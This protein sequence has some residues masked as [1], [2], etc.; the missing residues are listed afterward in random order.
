LILDVVWLT[1]LEELGRAT[2][3]ISQAVNEYMAIQTA[4]RGADAVG[5]LKGHLNILTMFVRLVGDREIRN[6]T[7]EHVE[8]FFYGPGG[9][10]DSHPVLASGK[11]SMYP[12]VCNR[13]HN[14]YRSRLTTFFV[15]CER[16]GYIKRGSDL[17]ALTSPLKVQKEVRERPAPVV[18]LRLLEQARNPR[19]RALM[20]TAVNTALRASEITAIRF[21]D[22][23]LESGVI[24]VTVRKTKDADYQPISMDLDR[25]LRKWLMVYASTLG[26]PLA[27]DDVLFP[28]RRGGLISH[29][30]NGVCIRHPY[31]W[32]TQSTIEKPYKIVQ[33]A[34]KSLGLPTKKEGIHT[35]RRAVALA[36]FQQVSKDQGDVAALRETAALLHHSSVATTEIYLGMTPEKNRRDRRIKGQ[37]FLSAMVHQENVIQLAERSGS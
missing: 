9:I 8:K 35:I 32:D 29:Y 5:T 20:A 33:D 2:V 31:T 6:L 17:M 7:D 18:L 3:K 25:E 4:R 11:V 16:K 24:K 19:D 1:L 12:P 13:T 36:Y 22:V 15:W 27:E 37:P 10:R 34:L 23:D 28:V 26:R 30:D 14:H 21:G